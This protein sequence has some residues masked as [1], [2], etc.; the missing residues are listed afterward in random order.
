MLRPSRAVRVKRFDRSIKGALK[1]DEPAYQKAR[2]LFLADLVLRRDSHLHASLGHLAKGRKKQIILVM[3]NADQRNLAV[4]QEAF[5]IAQELAA[6]RSLLIFVALRPSTFYQSKTTGALS[7]YQHKI[8]TISP[9]PADDVVQRRLGFA[10]RVA[11]GTIEPA[12]L[13]GIRLQA[14][15]RS[16][17]PEGDASL[18]SHQRAN[19]LTSSFWTGSFSF[20]EA[21]STDTPICDDATRD[22]VAEL[23]ASFKIADRYQRADIVNGAP[24]QNNHRPVSQ[25]GA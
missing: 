18:N 9:P 23:A 22:V 16:F 15:K 19:P 8:L 25:N 2:I 11:E 13:S 6:T 5:L 21:T 3:D 1:I 24:P 7:G 4:Q 14:W 12:A 20:L 17:F 10:V